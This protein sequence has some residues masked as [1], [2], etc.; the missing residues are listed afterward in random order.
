MC[1]KCLQEKGVKL[2]IACKLS[3]I[4]KYIVYSVFKNVFKERKTSPLI[5]LKYRESDV[6]SFS[7]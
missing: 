1:L 7:I 4:N 5:A 2:I 6:I 3:S